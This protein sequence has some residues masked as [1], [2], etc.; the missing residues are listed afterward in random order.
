MRDAIK[1]WFI[2]FV[3]CFFAAATI[4]WPLM[5]RADELLTSARSDSDLFYSIYA[6]W[7]AGEVISGAQ[8]FSHNAGAY[9]PEGT[10]M[11]GSVW[12]FVTLFLTGWLQLLREPVGA[13]NSATVVIIALNGVA[14]FALGKR[15]GGLWGGVVAAA[16]MLSF[17]MSWC[18]AFEGRHEQAFTAPI[19]L[20]FLSLIRL[21]DREPRAWLGFGLSLALVASTYWYM[22][23]MLGL[24]LLPI[25]LPMLRS[26]GSAIELARGMG[27]CL[28]AI[29][30]AIIIIAPHVSSELLAR[31]NSPEHQLLMR[32]GNSLLLP[33]DS[34]SHRNPMGRALPIFGVLAILVSL[35]KKETRAWGLIGV[36]AVILTMGSVLQSGGQPVVVGGR[37]IPLPLKALDLL[38][39]FDRFWWP[40]RA[41]P[42]AGCAAATAIALIVSK[43]KNSHM[44][45][46]AAS[47]LL[48]FESRAVIFQALSTGDPSIPTSPYDPAPDSGFYRLEIPTWV[49]SPPSEGAVVDHPLRQVSNFAPLYA[50]YH[51]L[52]MAI[53]DGAHEPSIRPTSFSESIYGSQ[54]L[55]SWAGNTPL[56]STEA[57]RWELANRGYRW[58][59]WHLP[60]PTRHPNEHASELDKSSAASNIFGEPV[61]EDRRLL[62]FSITPA[63]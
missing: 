43:M 58:F 42:I 62:V 45:A 6:H 32:T 40:Y 50:T 33:F 29:L 7:W 34:L 49:E 23:P 47:L 13:W 19:S 8:S 1:S 12:N 51:R 17:P 26:R 52:P 53:G 38:P 21:S 63:L 3:L 44:V 61:S 55:S 18:E 4:S 20:T 5:P 36:I 54:L 27:V 16:M 22:A 39:G 41:L 48:G 9:F 14:G 25:I 46:I 24:A 56:D 30:P 2:V 11:A 31:S 28:L 57:D 15:V 37:L 35:S 60:D 59:L 10:D